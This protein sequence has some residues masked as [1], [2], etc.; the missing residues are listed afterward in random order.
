MTIFKLT[1]ETKS[2]RKNKMRQIIRIHICTQTH[3]KLH[4]NML[5]DFGLENKILVNI[6]LKMTKI[7]NREYGVKV[8]ETPE[9]S[10]LK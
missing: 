1:V 4:T 9:W 5:H 8:K 7:Q 3:F 6:C 2:N 10:F